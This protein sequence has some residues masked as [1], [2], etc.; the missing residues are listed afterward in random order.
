MKL[1][2]FID[3][4]GSGGAQRQ[5]V[6]LGKGFK[7]KGHEVIFL[8]Y[9][10]EP[11]FKPDLDA[12]NIPIKIVSEPN[13]LKRIFKI[14]KVIRK[15][16]PDAVLSFLEPANFM[17]TLAGLPFRKWKLVVGE[18]SANPMIYKSP[19]KIIFRWF[20]C[21]ADYVVA[22]SKTNLD[23]VYKI[24]PFLSKKKGKVIYNSIDFS[25][26]KLNQGQKVISDKLNL[27]IIGRYH[28]LK[29]FDNLVKA[30]ISLSES[31]KNR[32]IINWYGEKVLPDYFETIVD[33]I[34][35]H[36]LERIIKLNESTL[37]IKQK[38]YECDLVGLFSTFEGF[39][40]VICEAMAIGKPVICTKVSDIPMFIKEDVNGFLCEANDSA[41][42]ARAIIKA[43][44]STENERNKMGIINHD[45]AFK[46]FNKEI[47]IND[48]LRLLK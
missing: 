4:L 7:E 16:K 6:E 5:L 26:W 15:E 11:F 34:T 18:R 45:T 20:H 32:L 19:K 44:N 48:Y 2:L 31:Y 29:N 27:I 25:I 46:N 13:Y 3:S 36:G 14:R 24:N 33:Q 21:F 35:K 17:A 28:P 22:N 41:S 12:V 43:I 30:I 1:L 9:H 40:N 42:I 8:V 47:V 39:P 37:N 38:Y 10:D 23:M